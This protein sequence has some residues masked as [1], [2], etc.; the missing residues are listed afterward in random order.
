MNAVLDGID[1]GSESPVE[2]LKF[3]TYQR[4]ML[5]GALKDKAML[6]AMTDQKEAASKVATAYLEML[7]PISKMAEH[8]KEA[9]LEERLREVEAMSKNGPLH[10][11]SPSVPEMLEREGIVK[12]VN[13]PKK[14]EPPVTVP[15]KAPRRQVRRVPYRGKFDPPN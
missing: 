15:A 6:L 2:R 14:R 11:R 9:A 5:L 4:R 3:A 10:A 1:P 7:I 12:A 8:A 13:K